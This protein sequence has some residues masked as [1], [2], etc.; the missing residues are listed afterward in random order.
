MTLVTGGGEGVVAVKAYEVQV[1]LL[2]AGET[3]VLVMAK[4]M[5]QLQLAAFV[6]L[7]RCCPLCSGEE[8][9]VGRS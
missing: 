5:Q 4:L 9:V 2:G 3:A 1:E 7:R 8:A 6:G